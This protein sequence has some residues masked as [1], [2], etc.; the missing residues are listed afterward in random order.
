V[1]FRSVPP[2]FLAALVVDAVVRRWA[3]K[4]EKVITWI[5]GLKEVIGYE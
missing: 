4:D 5:D 3:P 1:L 2:V